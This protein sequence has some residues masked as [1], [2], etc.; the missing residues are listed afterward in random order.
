MKYE[1]DLNVLKAFNSD[2]DKYVSEMECLTATA[3]HR[4]DKPVKASGDGAMAGAAMDVKDTC[5]NIDQLLLRMKTGPIRTIGAKIIK[6]QNIVDKYS[7][8]GGRSR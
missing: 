8:G 7:K 3:R 1:V 2:L 4:A 6:Y 5:D